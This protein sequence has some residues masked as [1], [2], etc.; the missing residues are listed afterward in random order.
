AARLAALP[1]AERNYWESVPST[2]AAEQDS[3]AFLTLSLDAGGHAID[4]ENSDPATGLFL[5][6]T[7][8]AAARAVGTSRG[9]V[10]RDVR[11]F[12]LAYPVG[13]LVP[14]VGPVVT[15]DAYA[16]PSVWST[17]EK[18]AYHGPRV[19]WGREVNLFLLGTAGLIETA[20]ADSAARQHAYVSAVRAALDHVHTAV[21]SAGF[22][23]E[24]WT[25]EIVDGRPKAL[26]YGTGSDVQL[27]ST[28]DLAVE[29]TLERSRRAP[30]RFG[31]RPRP[32]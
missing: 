3:L 27:W 7:D 25:Y 13:L 21:D 17:F 32:R 16:S 12:A 15:N 26:R 29:F 22:R 2:A 31:R 28:S 9:D 24:L 10:L 19:A 14:R 4:I 18:D 5:S 8:S 6:G 23:S 11:T 30:T 1:G 20:R